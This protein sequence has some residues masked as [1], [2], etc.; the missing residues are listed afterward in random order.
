[1]SKH[2]AKQSTF[3]RKQQVLTYTPTK[4]GGVYK[5]YG[6]KKR[7]ENHRKVEKK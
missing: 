1:M 3:Q 6:R 4:A 2:L 7:K 5:L